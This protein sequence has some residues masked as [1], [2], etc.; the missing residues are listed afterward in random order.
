[1][2]RMT[3]QTL[4]I[5]SMGTEGF[6]TAGQAAKLQTC[7]HAAGL[8]LECCRESCLHST[9]ID[10]SFAVGA[11]HWGLGYRMGWG[12]KVQP[13]WGSPR[14]SRSKPHCFLSSPPFVF[15]FLFPFHLIPNYLSQED[16]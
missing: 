12:E 9:P 4:L 10:L 1:M 7:H 13:E 2:N 6:Q 8:M 15:P 3:G 16:I 11:R 5:S 14:T